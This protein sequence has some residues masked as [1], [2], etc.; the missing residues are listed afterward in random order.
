MKEKMSMSNAE[1]KGLIPHFMD[2]GTNKP[3][4]N[5]VIFKIMFKCTGSLNV[6]VLVNGPSD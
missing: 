3:I 4:R 6:N 1:F 2:I 5:G